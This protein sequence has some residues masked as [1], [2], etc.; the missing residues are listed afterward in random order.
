MDFIQFPDQVKAVIRSKT[1]TF[2]I[3][4]QNNYLSVE[5]EELVEY[6]QVFDYCGVSLKNFSQAEK[7]EVASALVQIAAILLKPKQQD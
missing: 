5:S 3:S 4:L 7:A 6:D 1:A 2:S